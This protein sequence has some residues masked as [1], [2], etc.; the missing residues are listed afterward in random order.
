MW[1]HAKPLFALRSHVADGGDGG[2][3]ALLT[4]NTYVSS[5]VYVCKYAAST[6]VHSKNCGYN[7]TT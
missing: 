6:P 7:T 3:Q 4:H 2:M 1:K 5:C